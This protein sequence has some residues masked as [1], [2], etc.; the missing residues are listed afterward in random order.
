MT[1]YTEEELQAAIRAEKNEYVK[2]WKRRNPERAREIN[3]RYWE[4]RARARLAAKA[5][6]EGAPET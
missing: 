4:K 5:E 2:E 1:E 6:K 3:K